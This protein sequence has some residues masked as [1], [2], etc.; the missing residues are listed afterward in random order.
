M[1]SRDDEWLYYAGGAALL[2]ILIYEGPTIVNG[3]QVAA[4]YVMNVFAR[5]NSLSDSSTNDAGVVVDDPE[6]LRMQAEAVLGYSADL[7]TYALARM[8]RSEGVDGMEA[9]MHVALNDLANLQ[10]TYGTNVY[11]SISQL[12]LHT[13]VAGADQHFGEQYLGKRYSTV[14]DPFEGDYHLAEKVRADRANGID[15]T[16]GALKFVDK[17]S[18]STQRGSSGSYEAKEA[19]WAAAGLQPV[20]FPGATDNFVLFVPA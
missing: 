14:K 18:F 17:D 3:A 5:G 20:S 16:G 2:G 11:S 10:S 12:M 13:K 15:I 9:R 7:D 8:G 6:V 4:G 19:E 1:S